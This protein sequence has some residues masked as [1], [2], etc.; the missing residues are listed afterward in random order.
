MARTDLSTRELAELDRTIRAAEIA[1]RFEFSVYVGA[2]TGSTADFARSLHARLV[3]P[4]ISVLIMLDPSRRA[5][6]LVTGERVRNRISDE[7][8]ELAVLGMQSSLSEGDTLGA[9][10]RALAQLSD[11][12]H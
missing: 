5:I 12:A 4:E 10:K 6:E 1:S 2:A 11:A 3:V 7:Q 9:L 8:L